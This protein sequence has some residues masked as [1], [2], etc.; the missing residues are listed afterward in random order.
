MEGI[1]ISAP[2]AL[3]RVEGREH[4]RFVVDAGG[5]EIDG[6]SG[7]SAEVAVAEIEIESADVVSAAGAGKFHPAFDAPDGVVSLHNL[8]VVFWREKRAHV[9]RA[10]KVTS[11]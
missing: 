2:D 5:V 4:Y 10:A 1:R 9:G 8:S 7:L 11:G 3:L 6:G